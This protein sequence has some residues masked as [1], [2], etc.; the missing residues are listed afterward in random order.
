MRFAIHVQGGPADG[1]CARAALDF[2]EAV[3]TAGHELARVFFQGAGVHTAS[4]LT[5][6]PQ[7]ERDVAV[8]WAEFGRRHEV[9]L[10]VCVASALRHGLLDEA[11]ARRYARGEGNLH[12]AFQISGLGQLIDAALNA[13]RVVTFVP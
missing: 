2:A 9:D 4:A 3:L 7:D 5:V 11:E 10:V 6:A 1:D 13:D 8:A 12:S